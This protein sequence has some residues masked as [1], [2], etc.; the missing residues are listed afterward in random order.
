[1]KIEKLPSGSYRA[2]RTY[3]K[4]TFTVMFKYKPSVREAEK[5]LNELIDRPRVN[6]PRTF[7][8]IAKEFFEIK[9]NVLSPSTLRGYNNNLKGLSDEFKKI[10]VDDIDALAVQKEIN[11]LSENKSP[12]TVKNYHGFISSVLSL[13]RPDLVLKT[14]LPLIVKK[15]PYVPNKE[16]LNIIIRMSK[17]TPYLQCIY[18]ASYGMRFSEIAALDESSIDGNIIH[19]CKTRV[20]DKDGNWIIKDYPKTS[21]S[22]RDIIVPDEVIDEIR[23]QGFFTQHPTSLFKWLKKAEKEAGIPEFSIHKLRHFFASEAH[24]LG[25]T[26]AEIQQ[27]GGWE[28]DNVMKRVY[29]HAGDTTQKVSDVM[30]NSILS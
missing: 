18:L 13:Y 30:K 15:D 1:M 12:K 7:E 5:A 10:K 27:F 24:A 23:E 11:I 26:D 4:K 22:A 6:G 21:A 25:L 14:K 3:N 16:E 28:T 19:I 17:G 2:R 8:D 29:R 9:S 20:L